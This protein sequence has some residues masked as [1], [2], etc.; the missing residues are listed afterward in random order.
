MSR[1]GNK[2]IPI[3]DG[4][5]VQ[6]ADGSVWVE[7]PRGKL[8]FTAPAGIGVAV[9]GKQV[10]CRRPSDVRQ[11]KALHGLTRSLVA[12]MIAGVT[13]GFEKRLELVG[14]GYRAAMQGKNLTLTLGFSHPVVFPVPPDITIE[15]KD[16]TQLTIAGVDKQKVGAVAAILRRLRPPE[17]YKGKGVMYAGEVIRRKAGKTG[18]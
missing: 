10:I 4:V 16:Q 7:G 12:N 11:H 14:V 6:V 15:V 3:P 9:E 5:K 13:Q 8:S 17:P 2:P 1:V 18:A